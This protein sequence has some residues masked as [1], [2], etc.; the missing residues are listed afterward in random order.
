MERVISRKLVAGE[1]VRGWMDLDQVVTLEMKKR[2]WIHKYFVKSIC[3]GAAI[4]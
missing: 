4:D 1:Q 2:G 3:E